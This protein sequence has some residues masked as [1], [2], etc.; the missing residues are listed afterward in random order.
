[1]GHLDVARQ[2]V[3][4]GSIVNEPN[5]VLGKGRNVRDES[6]MIVQNGFTSLH[7]ACQQSHPQI[8][9]FLILS[10]ANMEAMDEV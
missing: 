7:W 2:L 5:Q 8:V 10:G 4:M 6:F 1:M 3:R 9:R